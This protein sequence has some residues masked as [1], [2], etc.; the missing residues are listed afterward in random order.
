MRGKLG[1]AKARLFPVATALALL[2]IAPVASPSAQALPSDVCSSDLAALPNS[3][4]PIS[5]ISNEWAHLLYETLVQRDPDGQG[6]ISPGL[7]THWEQSKTA[8]TLHLRRGVLF[9]DG[10]PF[11]AAAVKANLDTN[12][13]DGG[14]ASGNLKAIASI[15]VVDDHMV[16]LNL[17]QPNPFLLHALSG[18]AVGMG[19]PKAL[20]DG[21][22][23]RVPVG[24]G[25]M[26]YNKE[27]T[28]P[29]GKV[30]L[31]AFPKYWDL[32][33]VRFGHIEVTPVGDAATRLLAVKAGQFDMAR[34]DSTVLSMAKGMP[35]L[36]IAGWP[37]FHF[38]LVF[39]D[40]ASLFHDKRVRQAACHALNT[41]GNANLLGQGA[42]VPT[43]QRFGSRQNGHSPDFRGYTYAPQQA[44]KL[45]AEAGSPAISFTLP[46]HQGFLPL[47]Q[48][49]S[50]QLGAVGI[51][52]KISQMPLAQYLS[53]WRSGKYPAG[54]GLLA[55]G[56]NPYSFYETLLAPGAPFNYTH[57]PVPAA[58]EVMRE[59]LANDDPAKADAIWRNIS[60]VTAA[61]AIVCSNFEFM[62]YLIYNPERISG[63]RGIDGFSATPLWREIRPVSR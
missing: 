41:A 49:M 37:A 57:T 9:H 30:V 54:I 35:D 25:P 5:P 22:I 62:Q 32:A 21:S 1:V 23:Q 6:K 43:G 26:Q 17:R 45:L 2:S 52:V 19:A 39:F 3:W 58:D 56:D 27:K 33:S 51:H 7:A 28:I 16:R 29:G 31:D 63:V 47:A 8:V 55:T 46:S 11:N 50:S 12:L 34:L 42:L 38:M 40:R 14:Y 13:K 20:L 36:K 24:T 18:S 15:D 10:E 59:G 53:V 60:K 48:A 61:E 44:R 4:S